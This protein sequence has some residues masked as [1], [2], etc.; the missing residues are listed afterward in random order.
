M[1]DKPRKRVLLVDDDTSLLVTVADFLKF[2]GYDVTTADSGEAGLL[3]LENMTPDVI[4][5]DMGMPG[6]GGVGFLREISTADGKLR[7]P[8]LVLTARSNMAEFFANVDVDG[9]IAKPCDPQDLLMEVGRIVFL[10][11]AS[12]RDDGARA[13]QGRHV[14]IAEDEDGVRASIAEAFTMAGFEVTGVPR[15]PELIE[16]AVLTPPDVVVLKLIFENMNGDTVAG[17]LRGMPRTASV[18]IVLYDDS[19]G[20]V[21]ARK[22]RVSSAIV[23]RFVSTNN[24]GDLL[25]AVREVLEKR[26]A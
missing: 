8:V 11:S 26:S 14:I 10:R 6:M 13:G 20:T 15:G 3:R 12:S 19:G 1:Q 5:L 17:I 2:E 7:Y 4:I 18:G 22:Y 9:F 21:S 25:A 16:A 24:P 23:D